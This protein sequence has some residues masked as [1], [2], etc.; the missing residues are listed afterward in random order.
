M[1]YHTFCPE[2]VIF[3]FFQAEDG[4]RDAQESRGLGDVYKRQEYTPLERIAPAVEHLRQWYAQGETRSLAYRRDQLSQLRR[5]IAENTDRLAEAVRLDMG[6]HPSFT[7]QVIGGCVASCDDCLENLEDWAATRTTRSAGPPA[8]ENVCQVRWIPRGTVLI[9]GTWNFP[10]PLVWKPLAS[11]LAAGNTVLVK[12]N[13]VCEH[14]SRLMAS[15]IGSYMDPKAVTAIQG[16]VE[17]ATEVL[18]QRFDLIFYTGNTGV[19][20]VVMRAAAEHLTPCVLELG[21]K[22]PVVVAADA[23]LNIAARKIVDGRFKN[24]GQFCV[25]PDY[26]LCEEEVCDALV[27]EMKRAVTEFFGPDPKGCNSYGRIINE[28]H[29]SRVVSLLQEHHGGEV[30]TGGDYDV[31]ECYVGPTIV[32]GPRPGSR[33]MQEEIF[34]PILVVQPISDITAAIKHINSQERSLALYVFSDSEVTV[35]QVIDST[36]SG[37]ACA[38]DVIIHMLNDV[39]PFGGCGHSGFGSYHGEWGFKAFSHEKGVML[40]SATDEGGTRFPPYETSSL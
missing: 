27:L 6:R 23:D 40:I 14:T 20:R 9:V 38:N 28:R 2:V 39:L 17:V 33:L 21:G 16:G 12:L 8:G 25:A 18:R 36:C 11:A 30:V 7:K 29:T 34:G 22:N 24:T 15:L 26:V 13:E 3:F 4:I 1:C 19:G 35:D 32:R 31:E 10:N 37:G 5:L